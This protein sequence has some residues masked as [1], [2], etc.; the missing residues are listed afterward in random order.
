MKVKRR[1]ILQTG[2]LIAS[3]YLASGCRPFIEGVESRFGH[4]LPEIIP[5]HHGEQIDDDFHLLSRFSF[6]PTPNEL[7][8]IKEIGSSR[9]FS[10]QLDCKSIDD[11]LASLRTRRFESRFLSSGD[12]FDVKREVLRS[13]LVRHTLLKSIYS[14]KQ[15]LE[16][17][18]NF[19]NDHLNINLEKGNCVYFKTLDDK[20]VVRKNALGNFRDLIKASSLSAAMLEYLDGKDNK[21][22]SEEDVP[23]E[24][25]A[26]ELLELHTLGVNGGYTQ[27]D[28]YEAARCLTGWRI[29]EKFGRGKVFFEP[30]F[31]DDGKKVVLGKQINS[32]GGKEDLEKLL[33]IVCFHEATAR[34]ISNK[35]ATYFVSNDCSVSLVNELAKEFLRT[36][37]D[38]KS[39]LR[40]IVSSDQFRESK[41]LL[42]KRPYRFLVS[43]VRAL[44]ASTFADEGL[45][46]YLSRMGQEPFQYPTPDGFPKE[47][48]PWLGTLLWRWNFALK[49]PL[50]KIEA[51]NVNSEELIESIRAANSNESLTTLVFQYLIGR[52]PSA[53]ELLFLDKY[54][55]DNQKQLSDS[56]LEKSILGVVMASPQ[57]QRY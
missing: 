49:L 9:W 24:N 22:E 15:L 26:R 18:T 39:L 14:R 34:H 11:S 43:S 56:S 8:Y 47:T 31:H 36:R 20:D 7:N 17:M 53:S 25:Y 3:S 54:V 1:T 45:V 41:G 27:K 21:R 38:I 4:G 10:E 23:N 12:C 42:F 6:G 28:V 5:V 13:D 50:N 51:V 55:R 2:A 16:V 29:K 44:G 35:L 48:L 32:G 46:Q 52:S 57:F 19:W 37:G 40:I 33:D 30:K